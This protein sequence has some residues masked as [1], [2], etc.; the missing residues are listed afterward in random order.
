MASLRFRE[1]TS[2]LKERG[3]RGRTALWVSEAAHCQSRRNRR[4]V[5]RGRAGGWAYSHGRALFSSSI[6]RSRF[7]SIP[8]TRSSALGDGSLAETYLNIPKIGEIIRRSEAPTRFIPGYGF[9]VGAR[10]P[11]A[12]AVCSETAAPFVRPES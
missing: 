2:V 7:I 5:S 11:F 10:A 12:E 4:F 1:R 8:A 3:R 6:V 9:L